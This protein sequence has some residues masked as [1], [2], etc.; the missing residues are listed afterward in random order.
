MI[1]LWGAWGS[2]LALVY[3]IRNPERVEGMILRGIFLS[4]KEEYC[5][6]YATFELSVAKLELPTSE[7]PKYLEEFNYESL[8]AIECRYLSPK[9]QSGF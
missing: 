4:T 7:I 9:R 8:A 6:A 5:R 1:T 2:T 3:A